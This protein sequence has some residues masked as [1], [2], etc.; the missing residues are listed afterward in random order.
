MSPLHTLHYI[1]HTLYNA[2][3]HTNNEWYICMDIFLRL[4]EKWNASV[5]FSINVDC[6]DEFELLVLV[7]QSERKLRGR[8][9]HACEAGNDISLLGIHGKGCG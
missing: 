9:M 7:L 4:F 2:P 8:T 3:I 5:S 6:G 1:F